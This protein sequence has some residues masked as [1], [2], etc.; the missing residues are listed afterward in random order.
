MTNVYFIFLSPCFIY[1]PFGITTCLCHSVTTVIPVT[2]VIDAFLRVPSG[3][4]HNRRV[5]FG[6][7]VESLFRILKNYQ[8]DMI[9]GI[10]FPENRFIHP[11]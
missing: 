6:Q 1:I 10:E 4:V 3:F 11:A 2:T 5:D 7:P 8:G 9:H